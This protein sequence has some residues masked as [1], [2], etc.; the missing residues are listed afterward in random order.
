MSVGTAVGLGVSVGVAVFVGSGVDVDVGTGVSV[1]SACGVRVAVGVAGIVSAVVHPADKSAAAANAAVAQTIIRAQRF[2]LVSSM[3]VSSTLD[4]RMCGIIA[5]AKVTATDRG[6]TSLNGV[7][8][9]G[10]YLLDSPLCL[11]LRVSL[12]ICVVSA[13]LSI[14]VFARLVRLRK[15]DIIVC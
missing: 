8:R 6:C 13:C 11:K 15:W 3:P 4:A 9:S 10:I 2:F 1:C 14:R 7:E 12:A 5:Q